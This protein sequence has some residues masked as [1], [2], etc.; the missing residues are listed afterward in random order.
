MP[1]AEPRQEVV[2]LEPRERAQLDR[3]RDALVAEIESQLP[4]EIVSPAEYTAI[5][6]LEAR[7]GR[8]ID[9]TEPLFDEHCSAAHK[10]WKQACG[11]RSLFLDAPKTLKER[12]RALL[13]AYKAAEARHRAEEERRLA[14]EQQVAERKR[15]NDEAKLAEKQGEKELAKAIRNTPVHAPAVVLPSAVPDVAGLSYREDWT[16]EPIGGDTPAYRMRALSLLVRPEY[17]QLLAFNDAAL[18][19]F[20]RRTKGTIRVPGIRFFSKQVPVRR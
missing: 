4:T 11:I 19:Q 3:D 17:L 15:L 6:D 20:A 8:F 12:C 16:W 10:V 14:L 7:L 2:L 18:T 9:R 1:V 13:G 5:A